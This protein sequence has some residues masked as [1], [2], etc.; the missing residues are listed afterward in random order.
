M[1]FE[2]FI[3]RLIDNALNYKLTTLVSHLKIKVPKDH[4]AHR[5]LNDVIMTFHVWSHLK[6]SIMDYINAIP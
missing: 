2:V 1:H 5:A 6:Q 4:R 3:E